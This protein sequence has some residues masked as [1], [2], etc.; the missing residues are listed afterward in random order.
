[1]TRVFHALSEFHLIS[2][3][4]MACSI[5]LELHHSIGMLIHM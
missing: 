4:G 5:P 2:W 3:H 1:M